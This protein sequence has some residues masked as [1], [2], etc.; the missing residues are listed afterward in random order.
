MCIRD[1]VPKAVKYCTTSC[2]VAK[3]APTNKPTK[4]IAMAIMFL[5]DTVA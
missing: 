4:D 3:P 5:E 1:R 2:P